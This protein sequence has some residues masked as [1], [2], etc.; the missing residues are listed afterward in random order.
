VETHYSWQKEIAFWAADQEGRLSNRWIGVLAALLLM[1]RPVGASADEPGTAR[2]NLILISMDTTRADALSCYGQVPGLLRTRGEVTPTLDRLAADGMRFSRFYAH[3]PTTLNSHAS[4]LTGLDP[5][6]HQVAR[7]GFPL[8]EGISTL[9][10]RLRDAGWDTLAVVGAMA[11]ERAMGLDRGFR[12]YDDR[13]TVQLGP[14]VQDRADGVYRRA[15]EVL[16][17][18]D[19]DKPLFLLVHFFD[20]HQPYAPPP[21]WR[22]RFADGSYTGPWRTR[23]GALGTLRTAL[24]EE[25]ALAE[26]IDQVAALYLAE[27][28]FMDHTIGLLLDALRSEG[29]LDHAV[30]VVVADHGEVLS[31]DPAFAWSHGSDVSE[32]VMRVPLIVRGYGVP[33]AERAVIER[34]AEMGGLAPT[35][36]EVLGLAPRLGRH[37]SFFELLRPGPV[38]DDD[39]WPERPTRP[40]V[41]EATR[42]HREDVAPQWNNADL[43]RGLRAGGWGVFASPR[44][45]I[46][47]TLVAGPE[48]APRK[49]DDPVTVVLGRMLTAWDLAAP[50]FREVEVSEET[51]A[52][53]E[54]LGYVEGG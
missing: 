29:L 36:E 37:G 44:H 8:P 22:K 47:A 7:N 40:V 24:R 25:R 43:L 41:L 48:G 46:P 54:A 10:E 4:M 3:A 39:G 50:A 15:M 20:P 51:R 30:V 17:E 18:R 5:H 27:V 31:E 52:A 35:L 19:R 38:W 53:L 14:M 32:G 13:M 11:L 12:I 1:V 6:G 42:P 49:D 2:P 28:A 21:E 23:A 33:L 26:D 45:E 9:S 34:Q 16:Q